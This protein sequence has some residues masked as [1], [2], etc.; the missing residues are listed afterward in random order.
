MNIRNETQNRKIRKLCCFPFTENLT[1]KI[2]NIINRD[3]N[4][5][6]SDESTKAI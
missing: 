1:P 6:V 2:I 5:V 3:R 4:V